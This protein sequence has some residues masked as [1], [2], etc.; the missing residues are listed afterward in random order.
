V[1]SRLRPRRAHAESVVVAVSELADY[2]R[3]SLCVLWGALAGM[4]GLALDRRGTHRCAAFT[5]KR[6]RSGR[7][8]LSGGWQLEARLGELVLQ[9]VAGARSGPAALPVEGALEWG[10][11]RFSVS[12]EGGEDG[13]WRTTL[14]VGRSL[15]VRCWR[16]GDR[17]TAVGGETARRVKRYLSDAGV[18]GSEREGWPVVTAGD[19]IVWIPG[20]RR[21][22]A[23]TVPSGGSARH[24]VCERTGS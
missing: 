9:R 21:S 15:R 19:E 20:V 7:I 22:D 16:P 18:R 10:R 23:A 2:D 6:P 5:M 11:F 8:P 24:F 14:P 4:A 3:S 12:D 1:R 13:L 17:L